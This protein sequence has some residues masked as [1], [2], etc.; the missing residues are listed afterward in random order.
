MK[1]E[2]DIDP[3]DFTVKD[4]KESFEMTWSSIRAL[5]ARTELAHFEVEDLENDR[6]ILKGLKRVLKYYMPSDEYKKFM[7]P[8]KEGKSK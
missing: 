3:Q 4:L 8:Y 7:K 2:V 1:V 6:K 5:D